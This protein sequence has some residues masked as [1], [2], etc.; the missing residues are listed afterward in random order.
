MKG[1]K[2]KA[3]K[4]NIQINEITKINMQEVD[5]EN[6]YACRLKPIIEL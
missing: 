3:Q 2:R 1:K 5:E 4:K 6:G